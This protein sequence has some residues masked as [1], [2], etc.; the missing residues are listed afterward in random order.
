MKNHMQMS[1]DAR[2]INEGFARMAVAAFMADMNPTLE[3]LADV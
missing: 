3:E 2:S 1:F